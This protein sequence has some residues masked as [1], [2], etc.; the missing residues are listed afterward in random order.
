MTSN[1]GWGLFAKTH[2]SKHAYLCAAVPCAPP[3]FAEG[4]PEFEDAFVHVGKRKLYYD[5][6]KLWYFFNH[7]CGA[8]ANVKVGRNAQNEQIL[9]FRARRDISTAEELCYDYGWRAVSNK[10]ASRGRP[11]QRCLCGA[12]RC[13]VWMP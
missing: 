12:A 6:N 1:K 4:D 7:A 3:L 10:E 11:R 13:R 5:R 2:I 8:T 9:E